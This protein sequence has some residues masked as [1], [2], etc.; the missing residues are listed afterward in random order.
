MID[1]V[2][3]HVHLLL[4][5]YTNLPSRG[6]RHRC[7]PT[8]P[9]FGGRKPFRATSFT[10]RGTEKANATWRCW[11]ANG[12]PRERRQAQVMHLALNMGHV[13]PDELAARISARAKVALLP[14]RLGLSYSL[15][16][17]P[18]RPTSSAIV[19]CARSL[20]TML[21]CYRAFS[22]Y[23]TQGTSMPNWSKI[24]SGNARP[25]TLQ[26]RISPAAGDVMMPWPECAADM[27]SPSIPG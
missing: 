16:A 5:F 27:K 3:F 11:W 25:S 20:S 8:L 24:G 22:S 6:A 18:S 15:S 14:G 4:A 23:S 26:A 2:A 13:Q 21:P 9:L 17:A 19:C 10:C 1:T 7:A 12:Q